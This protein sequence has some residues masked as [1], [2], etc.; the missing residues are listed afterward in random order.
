MCGDCYS[1][2]LNLPIDENI[3]MF[4]QINN[5][6]Y[7]A[8]SNFKFDGGYTPTATLGVSSTYADGQGT[9]TATLGGYVTP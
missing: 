9:P 4:Q 8:D 7:N 5:Y 6:K 1:E 2:G 3:T